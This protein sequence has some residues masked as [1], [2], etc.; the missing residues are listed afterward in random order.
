MGEIV[1]LAARRSLCD[2]FKQAAKLL[3]QFDYMRF[4]QAEPVPRE[5][6]VLELQG[7]MLDAIQEPGHREKFSPIIHC[8]LNEIFQ[9]MTVEGAPPPSPQDIGKANEN[10]RGLLVARLMEMAQSSGLIPNHY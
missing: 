5:K 10:G 4:Y 2:R 7:K 8:T 9:F 6:L 1:S 3:G